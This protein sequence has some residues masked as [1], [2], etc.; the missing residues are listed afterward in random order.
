MYVFVGVADMS[1]SSNLHADSA[2]MFVWSTEDS[3]ITGSSV[4]DVVILSNLMIWDV[5]CQVQ[6]L[7]S[8]GQFDYERCL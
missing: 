7:Q 4:D 2:T 1:D 3:D 6:G 8:R 5:C